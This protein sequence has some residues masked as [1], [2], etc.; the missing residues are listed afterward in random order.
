[1][2]QHHSKEEEGK[3]KGSENTQKTVK[4]NQEV[5]DSMNKESLI[6]NKEKGKGKE[7][8]KEKEQ[9]GSNQNETGN[10]N[11]ND[12]GQISDKEKEKQTE[13]NLNENE[14][15]Q[16]EQKSNNENENQSKSQ[17]KLKVEDGKIEEQTSSG[18]EES[19][20]SKMMLPFRMISM[21]AKISLSKKSR[22]VAAEFEKQKPFRSGRFRLNS[23]GLK[24]FPTEGLTNFMLHKPQEYLFIYFKFYY[25]NFFILFYYRYDPSRPP[26]N[27]KRTLTVLEL[28]FNFLTFDSF[29]SN[30]IP[31]PHLQELM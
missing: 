7:K 4:E 16:E 26:M 28:C 22:I 14:K 3:H 6:E 1:M 10:K 13:K 25:F 30:P 27:Q 9:N 24:A 11:V 21:K 12:D 17:E 23:C 20:T 15:N 29:P 18:S 5:N 8:E 2:G 19:L 31:F